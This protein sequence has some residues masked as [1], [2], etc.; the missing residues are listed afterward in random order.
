VPVLAVGDVALARHA[1]AARRIRV[2]H[3]GDALGHGEVAG[4]VLA[5]RTARWEEVPGFWT[6]IGERTLKFA[7]WG[8]GFDDV[9]VEDRGDGAFTVWYTRDGFVVGVLTHERDEDYESGR[10]RIA[11]VEP[12][13]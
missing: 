13:P 8:D 12:A 4:R 5:G 10:G 6:T 11:R 9:R 1:I 2:E 3:W 7:G